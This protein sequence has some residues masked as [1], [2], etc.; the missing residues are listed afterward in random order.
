M[1]I[2]LIGLEEA[3][4]ETA[5]TANQ[6]SM[7]DN[8]FSIITIAAGVFA[9]YSA[10]TGK[11][12]AFRSDYPASMQ[13]EATQFLRKFLWIIGPA[14]LISGVL[15]FLYPES[16]WPYIG[17]IIVIIPTIIIY[18]ILFRKKFREDLKRMR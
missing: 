11:G 3:V 9:I 4:T 14:A 1:F 6:V 13:K 16:M 17:G 12:P 10:I 18:S 15:D 8:L 7:F 2:S 5:E